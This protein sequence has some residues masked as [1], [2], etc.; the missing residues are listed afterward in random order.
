MLGLYEGLGPDMTPTRTTRPS[1][2]RRSEVGDSKVTCLSGSVSGAHSMKGFGTSPY[3][4][5]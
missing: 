5:P 1:S 2:D 3:P 4:V